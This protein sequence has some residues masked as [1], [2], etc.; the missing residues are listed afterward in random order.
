MQDYQRCHGDDPQ[1]EE[2]Y[3]LHDVDFQGISFSCFLIGGCRGVASKTW[4]YEREENEGDA[5]QG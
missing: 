4:A 3:L 1:E 2:R 5:L